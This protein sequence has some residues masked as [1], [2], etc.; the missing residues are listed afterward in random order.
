MATNEIR[1]KG[2]T[3]ATD[4]DIWAST[5]TLYETKSLKCDSLEANTISV[6]VSD[7]DQSIMS[8]AKNDR[9]EYLR[10]GKLMGIYYLQSVERVGPVSY[11]LNAVS[12]VGL[13]MT[14]SHPGGIYTGETAEEVIRS[15]CGD[16][17]VLVESVY[18]SRKI[19]NWLPYVQPPASSARDNLAEV[20]FVLGA[21]LGVDRDG[22][23]RVEKLWDGYSCTIG[24]ARIH[25]EG[26]AVQ[27]TDPVSS[28]EVTEHQYVKSS[29][30]V[31]LFDGTAT[32]GT[33]VIFDAPAYD[34]VG[35]GI[36]VLESGA[37]YAVLSAGT[38]TLKGK[39]YNH[40][41]RTV[42]RTV[43]EGAEENVITI[44]DAHLV[45]ITNS[46]EISRRL[47]QYY[48][49]RETIQ[50]DTNPHAGP[51][52][53]VVQM[54][55][56]WDGQYV[57]TTIAQRDTVISGLLKSST[58]AL[59]GFLPPQPETAEYFDSRKILTGSGEIDIPAGATAIT[60]VLIQAGQGAGCGHPGE[61]SDPKNFS[62]S[63]SSV[64]FS[65]T[66]ATGGKGGQP[67]LPGAGGRVLQVNLEVGDATKLS[68]N[69]GKGGAA[70]PYDPEATDVLGAEGTDT[71]LIINGTTYSS[72]DGTSTDAGYTDPVTGE[73]FAA[74][75][76]LG[77]A[78]GAGSGLDPNVKDFTG[79]DW[80]IPTPAG[81]VTDEDG[82]V[83]SGGI[84]NKIDGSEL[85]KS[86][87]ADMS[88]DGQLSHGYY[89]TWAS[90]AMGSG[91]AVGSPG[92][93]ET[94]TFG[95]AYA[96]K[97][98]IGTETDPDTGKEHDIFR[99]TAVAQG[100]AGLPGAD[101]KTPPKT[102]SK[103][104]TGGTSGHGGGGASAPGWAVRGTAGS[105][106][107]G[108]KLSGGLYPGEAAE[109]GAGIAG[110]AG[111]DGCLILFFHQE[112]QTQVGAVVTSDTKW[113]LDSLGRWM[114]V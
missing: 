72:A 49:C 4:Q 17:P 42:S 9:V 103:Y 106:Q 29:E 48:S 15:I 83:W 45:S 20:L 1:Y 61:S 40:L 26:A 114:I 99:I 111:A 39:R 90:T 2:V 62:W 53:A 33:L 56:P 84:Y 16:I 68:Y 85:P 96:N 13:L 27:Y 81:S 67:G 100:C 107:G 113:L 44:Q 64:S 76:K 59:V 23:L 89:E 55:H 43:T 112:H 88:F 70:A 52:G 63:T 8:F 14:R 82:K 24:P 98:K 78:G 75:G 18:A 35:S 36:S 5:G 69:C 12:A 105:P 87:S 94:G 66:W 110:S 51:P 71:T 47:A 31:T 101:A 93:S 34:L 86:V 91:A 60:A 25:A 54:W 3:Y 11:T 7:S 77:V 19:Y 57:Q 65:G 74:K 58:D 46:V 41:T 73:T 30:E 21:W 104:G 37:N 92:N 28:V 95:T 32:E 80:E 79:S 102:P 6:T 10:D 109:G 50:V 108:N 97:V 22:V 38:G